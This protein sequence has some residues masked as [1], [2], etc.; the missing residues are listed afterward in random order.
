MKPQRLNNVILHPIATIGAS[1]VELIPLSSCALS[2]ESI[3]AAE[4]EWVDLAQVIA[5]A[6]NINDANR[7]TNLPCYENAKTFIACFWRAY[8]VLLPQETPVFSWIFNSST[9]GNSTIFPWVTGDMMEGELF[10]MK[11][12]TAQILVM[13]EWAEFVLGIIELI[14][15][16]SI[17]V[18]RIPGATDASIKP[19]FFSFEETPGTVPKTKDCFRELRGYNANVPIHT[20]RG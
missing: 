11:D 8:G 3:L 1:R 9:E 18:F 6:W 13:R 4:H 10:D 7:H 17:S 15:V 2:P 16:N 12:S 20:L 19:F 5:T 14:Q